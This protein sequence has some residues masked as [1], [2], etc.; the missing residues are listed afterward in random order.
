MAKIMNNA[1]RRLLAL[2]LLVPMPAG[3]F[4]G[5]AQAAQTP[6]AD[7]SVRGS[8]PAAPPNETQAFV[9]GVVALVLILTIAAAVM[10]Y[11]SRHRQQL[12]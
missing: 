10:W 6:H 4:L 5:T 11:T 9:V 7:V 1:A 12:R 2:F 8:A 3:L